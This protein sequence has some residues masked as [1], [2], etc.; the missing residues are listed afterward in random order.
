MATARR[1]CAGWRSWKRC[2]WNPRSKKVKISA[3]LAN[4]VQAHKEIVSLWP[5]IKSWL[6]SG[7]TLTLKIAPRGRSGPQNRL[8]HAMLYD[9]SRQVEWAGKKQDAETWKRLMVAAWCRS[10]GESV[11]VLPAI[12]GHGVDLVPVRTSKLTVSECAELCD[13]IMAWSVDRGVELNIQDE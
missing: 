3:T 12:D 7:T 5:Q 11:E 9:I 10:R 1:N 4:P 13:Y 2:R 8:L 6:L